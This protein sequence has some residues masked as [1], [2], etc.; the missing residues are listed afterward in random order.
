[1]AHSEVSLTTSS[2]S[3]QQQQQ[4]QI[5]RPT[6]A[7]PGVDFALDAVEQ[8][9]LTE[10][11]FPWLDS[12]TNSPPGKATSSK[13]SSR[14][15]N[16]PVMR[17]LASDASSYDD[18]SVACSLSAS[19]FHDGD[20]EEEEEEESS[21]H[22]T[23]HGEGLSKLTAQPTIDDSGM[24]QPP[25][26]EVQTQLNTLAP[27][28]NHSAAVTAQLLQRLRLSPTA[29]E[30]V[31]A[32]PLPSSRASTGQ[33]LDAS[34]QSKPYLNPNAKDFVPVA[35]CADTSSSVADDTSS[36]DA[37]FYDEYDGYVTEEEGDRVATP[38]A[39][40]RGNQPVF[41]YPAAVQNYPPAY[42]HAAHHHDLHY[43]H[44]AAIANHAGQMKPTYPPT[45]G[46]VHPGMWQ[47]GAVRNGQSHYSS[48]NMVSPAYPSNQQHPNFYHDADA[49]YALPRDRMQQQ[50][51][52]TIV[53]TSSMTY[54]THRSSPPTSN[55]SVSS[56]YVVRP[57]EED[58]GT[59]RAF[60][61][62]A[63]P[64]STTYTPPDS[65]R[66][67]STPEFS[68]S[69][70]AEPVRAKADTAVLVTPPCAAPADMRRSVSQGAY[71]HV[72]VC[73]NGRQLI[74]HTCMSFSASTTSS[75]SSTGQRLAS[76]GTA[77]G[78]S[79]KDFGKHF[80]E[81]LQRTASAE[82]LKDASL[83]EVSD[84]ASKH[85]A[86]MM[87]DAIQF[88]QDTVEKAHPSL[89]RYT[90]QTGCCCC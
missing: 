87:M 77:W 8:Q 47:H 15:T 19:D 3:Q 72:A 9:R 46:P 34:R 75:V 10:E 52:P 65:G 62:A 32:T 25:W 6:P 50:G 88:A 60:H 78:S 68:A 86:L 13:Q 53:T 20:E 61:V 27:V 5:Q 12:P 17:H 29:S 71:S 18:L 49:E 80:K 24:V 83:D 56:P 28:W 59:M 69:V 42:G 30:S 51:R 67:A 45:H 37:Y 81:L 23:P 55:D 22:Q 89:R 36:V 63:D 33:W 1:M 11:L 26:L 40:Q 58:V 90:S 85:E 4:Q 35:A 44:Q 41:S 7:S 31:P 38:H 66:S 84:V 73:C 64:S 76:T 82:S 48:G 79:V 14:G 21:G 74:D 57:I 54:P 43:H 70:T 2:A 16:T 39:P